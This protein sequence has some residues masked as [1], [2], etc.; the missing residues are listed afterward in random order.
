MGKDYDLGDGSFTM[1]ATESIDESLARLARQDVR[2]ST[3]GG[4]GIGVGAN[5]QAMGAFD[6]LR[7]RAPSV[8][9]LRR[10]PPPPPPSALPPGWGTSAP[11]SAP[12][13]N[14]VPGVTVGQSSNAPA[15]RDAGLKIVRWVIILAVTWFLW[16]FFLR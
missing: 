16:R 13:R 10:T 5:E 14:G 7:G 15:G 6:A 11:P 9:R 3:D 8:D 2:R 12:G 1:P 4:T